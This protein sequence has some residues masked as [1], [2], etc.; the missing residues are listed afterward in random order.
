MEAILMSHWF[1]DTVLAL[2]LVSPVVLAVAVFWLY[3][4]NFKKDQ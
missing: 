3:R 1:S 4:L 2:V